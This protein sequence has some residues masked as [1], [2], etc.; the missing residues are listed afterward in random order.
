MAICNIFKELTNTNGTFLT[1]SQYL[2]DITRQQT[3]STNYRVIPSRFIALDINPNKHDLD[4]I[5]IPQYI[6]N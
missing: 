2:E 3:L 5:N 4:S 1:F 6:Q